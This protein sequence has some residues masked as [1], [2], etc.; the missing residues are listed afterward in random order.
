MSRLF[1]TVLVLAL[2]IPAALAAEPADKLPAPIAQALKHQGLSERGLSIFVQ[3]VG[4]AAP[5]LTV[6]ADTPRNPAST[7]KLLTTLAALEELGPAYSWKTEAYA[8]AP[9]G[10]GVLN[11]DLY[12]KGYGD[13]YLVIEHFWR[14]LRALRKSGLQTIRGD[15]VIDQSYFE[16]V[17]GRPADF[18]HRPHRAYNVQPHALLV[19]FQAVNF[20]FLPQPG[21]QGVRIVADPQPAQL[22]IDNRV[23]LTQGPCRGGARG[24]DMRVAQ[25]G[26]LQKLVFSGRYSADCGEDGFYRVVTGPDS[27]VYGVFKSLWT[28]MGGQF[29]GG[30]REGTVPAGAQLLHSTDSPPLAEVI[31][32]VNKYSNNVMTRQILLTLGAEKYGPPGTVDKGS[33]AVHAWLAQKGLSFPELVLDNG[34]GLSRDG[35]ISARHLGE[36]LLTA[37]QSPYMPEFLASLPILSMDGTLAHRDGGPLAGRA[38]LKTGSLDNVRAQ[39]GIVLDE[40]GR[41]MVMVI[42]H[43]D[44]RAESAAGEAVQNALLAWINNRP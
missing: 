18:D 27:Y 13:P 8:T 25:N 19:N 37:W 35:R 23:R 32:D 1:S 28:E 26:T 12:I 24:L 15:L 34:S 41:R 9:V 43:N 7:M 20:R 36:L 21:A 5:L 16:P 40:H 14:F 10:N 22:V 30:M 3:E 44:A 39:A 31:R 4:Q 33:A 2:S 11:G 38:H 17:T 42:L 6:N 29:E